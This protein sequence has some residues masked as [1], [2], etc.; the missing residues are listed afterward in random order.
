MRFVSEGDVKGFAPGDSFGVLFYSLLFAA[1]IL[2]PAMYVW[3]R[4]YR[5]VM[6]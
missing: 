6:R 1:F 4:V 3:M 5:K 2:V